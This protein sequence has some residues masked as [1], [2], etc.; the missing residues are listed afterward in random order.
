MSNIQ[1]RLL[2]MSTSVRRKPGM[3]FGTQGSAAIPRMTR[4]LI[5]AVLATAA[6]RYSGPISVA[7][8]VRR[9]QTISVE[10]DGLRSKIFSPTRLNDWLDAIL[11]KCWEIAAV[12]G[13]SNQFAVE[14][15]DAKKS[16]RLKIQNGCHVSTKVF[17]TVRKPGLRITFQPLVAVFGSLPNEGLYSIAGNLRD[18]SLLRGGMATHFH[19]DALDGELAYFYQ[20]GLKSLLFEDDYA[21]WPLHPGCLSFK[22]SSKGMSVEGHLRFL[23]AGVPLVRNYVNFHPTQGGAHLEGLGVALRELFPDSSRGCRQAPFVTNP[24]TGARIEVPHTFIGAMHLR[25]DNPKYY[26]PTRDVLLGEEVCEFV[27]LA[28]SEPLKQQWQ[29]LRTR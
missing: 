2:S 21:R 5:D 23:H 27:R 28:A 25:T 20:H 24:D 19:A 17:P 16:A 6:S 7:V 22:A 4:G 29:A 12:A 11:S 9:L 14:A 10:F 26:G 8:T 3:Y 1:Q 18:L 15:C 13:A